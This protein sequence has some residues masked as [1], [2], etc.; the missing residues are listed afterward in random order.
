MKDNRP[1][2]KE[3]QPVALVVAFDRSIGARTAKLLERTGFDVL[4]CPGPGQPDFTCIGVRSSRCP[5]AQ[6]AELIVLDLWLEGDAEA[7]G[8]GS[9]ELLEYYRSTG[10][11]IVALDHGAE[12]ARSFPD[13]QVTVLAWPPD[14]AQLREVALASL[15]AGG[16]PKRVKGGSHEHDQGRPEA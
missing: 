2:G 8:T 3:R 6:T 11:P 14:P 15:D 13:Q 9:I 4:W 10:T 1:G 16:D 5:L 7:D 12:R